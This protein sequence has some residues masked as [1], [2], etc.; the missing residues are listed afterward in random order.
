MYS[1]RPADINGVESKAN[2]VKKSTESSAEPSREHSVPSVEPVNISPE[3]KQPE[4]S[5]K[6]AYHSYYVFPRSRGNSKNSPNLFWHEMNLK[7][8][9][10]SSRGRSLSP[11]LGKTPRLQDREESSSLP[12]SSI[13]VKTASTKRNPDEQQKIKITSK[14]LLSRDKVDKAL[15]TLKQSSKL[16][17]TAS[18]SPRMGVT[19]PIKLGRSESAVS[20]AKVK[21]ETTL[22]KVKFDLELQKATE[23]P[24]K[25]VYRKIEDELVEC[26]PSGKQCDLTRD[27]PQFHY[28][29]VV[30]IDFGTTFSGYAF[31][32]CHDPENIHIMR[33]WEG[34]KLWLPPYL[35]VYYICWSFAKRP[36]RSFCCC[37]VFKLS[38]ARI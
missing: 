14:P 28:H 2:L 19:K 6:S 10:S 11:D 23:K 13:L 38:R 30:A 21:S 8:L 31:S 25:K 15:Q 3:N 35:N 32:F 29:V 27:T 33:K 18:K 24:P 26:G 5:P 34:K 17:A 9:A 7:N 1:D 16:S 22:A 12:I 20:H 36:K 4:D 37:L